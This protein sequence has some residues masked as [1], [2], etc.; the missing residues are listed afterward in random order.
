MFV[1][2]DLSLEFLFLINVIESF[3]LGH[4][5]QLP[6]KLQK[7]YYIVSLFILVNDAV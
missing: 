6:K 7:V 2:G 1:S 4:R 5:T 3:D